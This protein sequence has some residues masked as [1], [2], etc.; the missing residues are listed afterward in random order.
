MPDQSTRGQI[1]EAADRLFYER[2]FDH[3]SFGD[4]AQVVEISRGNFYHH[5][6]SKDEILDAVIAARLLQTEDLLSQ[7]EAA[8]ADPAG[9]ILCFIHILVANQPLIL[10]HGCPV[11]S[12]C[13]E[14]AKLG[15]PALPLANGVFGLFRSWLRTQFVQLGRHAD[16][17]ALAM[18]LL[19]RSQGVAVLAQAFR[20]AAFVRQEVRSLERWLASCLPPAAGPD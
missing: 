18:H 20:D 10:Q 7:W 9:R 16:A 2:G 19:G 4:I 3:T 17:D 14:L 13:T 6:K 12:L 15:H 1:V 8:A 11:G 5:F